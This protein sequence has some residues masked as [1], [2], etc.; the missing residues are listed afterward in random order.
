MCA[1]NH[2]HA[3]LC[4]CLLCV[5][6]CVSFSRVLSRFLFLSLS[7]SFSLSL[8]LSLSL[9]FCIQVF[10]Y[11][12]VSMSLS[13]GA[14]VL[15]VSLRLSVSLFFCFSLSLCLDCK[16]THNR[17]TIVSDTHLKRISSNSIHKLDEMS[18]SIP[19]TVIHTLFDMQQSREFGI[20]KESLSLEVPRKNEIK[21][22]ESKSFVH[23]QHNAFGAMGWLR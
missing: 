4:A 11:L 12:C 8:S 19:Q 9:N 20:H 13:P 16:C 14:L 3:C 7:L 15:C 5:C 22:K 17:Q 1:R 10:V 21:R 23:G 18:G 2:A 6:A